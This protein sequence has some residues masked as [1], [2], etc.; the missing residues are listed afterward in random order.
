M[1]GQQDDRTPKTLADVSHLF[2]SRSDA[3]EQGDERSRAD[4]TVCAA[5]PAGQ[6]GDAAGEASATGSVPVPSTSRADQGHWNRTVVVPVTGGGRPGAS[7]IAVNLAHALL[8]WGRVALFDADGRLPN[9][10]FYLGLSSAHYLGHLTGAEPAPTTIVEG[11]LLVGDWVSGHAG[12][13]DGSLSGEALYVDVADAGR[14]AIDLAVVDVAPD[15]LEILRPIAQLVAAPVLVAEPS[16]DGFV[17]AYAAASALRSAGMFDLELV[18]NGIEAPE[19]GQRFSAKMR[20]AGRR[21][22][23]M[24]IRFAG[25]VR[26]EPR[27]GSRQRERGPVVRSEPDSV[28][29]LSLREVAA[30]V[31][32]ASREGESATGAEGRIGTQEVQP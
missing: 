30:N 27:L 28:A 26:R 4:A 13:D 14:R 9:A 12:P 2:F 21:L 7:T 8:P 5:G 18:V 31:L 25:A 19:E 32:A 10:R 6:A 16:F 1:S 22:L 20:E 23:D 15:R 24:E 29:A 3:S 11:G 17:G